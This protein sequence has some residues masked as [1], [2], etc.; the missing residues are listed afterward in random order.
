MGPVIL[1]PSSLVQPR[2]DCYNLLICR[3]T[4]LLL[5]W[6]PWRLPLLPWHRRRSFTSTRARFF[7]TAHFNRVLEPLQLAPPSSAWVVAPPVVVVAS[8]AAMALATPLWPSSPELPYVQGR[9]FV[10]M[11]VS[12]TVASRPPSSATCRRIASSSCFFPLLKSKTQ[13]LICFIHPFS[14]SFK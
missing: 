10:L 5:H 8:L 1:V 7:H 2:S 11:K 6:W 12:P 14:V 13:L 3:R 9:F 4:G